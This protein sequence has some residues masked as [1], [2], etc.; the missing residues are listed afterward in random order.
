MK[1]KNT[2]EN[3]DQSI[4]TSLQIKQKVS[5]W[6]LSSSSHG[7]PNLFRSKRVSI[8]LFWFVCFIGSLAACSISIIQTV[9]QYIQFDVTTNYRVYH[10]S[11]PVFPAITVCNKNLFTTHEAQMLIDEIE[12][13]N[14]KYALEEF[15]SYANFSKKGLFSVYKTMIR[16]IAQGISLSDKFNDEKR[17]KLGH[18]FEKFIY[19]CRYLDLDCNLNDFEW[20]YDWLYGNC[21]RFNTGKNSN[22]DA[23]PFKKSTRVG[24]YT[25]LQMLLY[26]GIAP[27]LDLEEMSIGAHLFIG[28][29]TYPLISL[30]G[31]DLSSGNEISIGV[32]KAFMQQLQ[33]PYSECIANL[34]N[35]DS[36]DSE[37]YRE[38]F[39]FN[40]A[41]R[42]KD[43][44]ELCF[45][46]FVIS[47]CKCAIGYNLKPHQ[48][49]TNRKGIECYVS[50]YIDFYKNSSYEV[51]ARECPRECST[52]SYPI[53]IGY[54]KFPSRSYAK[55]MIN[56]PYFQ[57]TYSIDSNASYETIVENFMFVDIFFEEL[58]Y[59]FIFEAATLTFVNLLANIGG[60]LGLFLVNS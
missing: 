39:S 3:L 12:R 25:G 32:N 16:M 7:L 24:K 52:T 17:K 5:E 47:R 6:I 11:T 15:F 40:K 21:Y 54:S 42:L 30:E 37:M 43:C 60:T 18:S 31:I 58:A 55:S 45:I 35:I 1:S 41:Y 50:S 29:S 4:A 51:C 34:N 59:T 22:G 13:E 33:Q 56:D 20:Y 23:I 27:E 9:V 38:T 44:I 14:P 46:R 2:H 26:V 53:S 36:Y 10:E 48:V 49:C 19:T 57:Q 8:K 28:N